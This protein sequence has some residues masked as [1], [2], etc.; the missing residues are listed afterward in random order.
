ML[1]N[2]DIE[3]EK[4]DRQTTTELSLAL[5][6]FFEI[7]VHGLQNFKATHPRQ[8]LETLGLNYNNIQVG[9]ISGQAHHRKPDSFREPLVK[10]GILTP[11][12]A[13]V[14]SPELKAYTSFGNYSITF[15]LKD[16]TGHIVNLYAYRFKI[17][18]PKEEYL[19]EE[20]LYPGFPSE[21]TTR[22][23]V[24]ENVIDAVSLL[25]SGILE[26]RDA[27]ISLFNGKVSSDIRKAIRELVALKEFIVFSQS[28][29]TELIEELNAVSCITPQVGILPEKSLN[30][31]WVKY[32][33]EGLQTFIDEI[34][35]SETPSENQLQEISP[36]EF[37]Y[38]GK[39]LTYHI[40]GILPTNP[41]LLEMQ[42]ELHSVDFSE[43]Y[44]IKINLLNL[45][46]SK[47]WLYEWTEGKAINY[48]IVLSELE[49]IR[50]QLQRIKMARKQEVL[51][52]RGF[53]VAQDKRAKQLLRSPDLMRELDEWIER[54]GVVGEEKTRLLLFIIA[55]SY[56]TMYNLHAVVQAND[57]AVGAELV[58]SIASLITE[59]DRYPLDVTTSRSFRY[60]GNSVINRKLLVIA[61]Y[62][63]II[64]SKAITD[65]K[66]LQA[67]NHFINDAPV[68]NAIGELVTN[69]KTIEGHTSSIGASS[70]ARKVFS[71][72]PKTVVI[73]LDTSTNQM[74]RLMEYDCQRIAGLIDEEQQQRAKEM[75]HYVLK[76]VHPLAVVNPHANSLMIPAHIPNA[77]N[78]TIQL[79]HFTNLITLFHQHQRN[80]DD[81]GRLIVQKEDLQMAMDLFLNTVVLNTD[82]LDAPTLELFAKL[83]QEFSAERLFT[84]LEVQQLGYSKTHT[85]RHLSLLTASEYLKKEG[86]RNTGFVY[87]IVQ[88]AEIQT[89]KKYI[90]DQL[91]N[92]GHSG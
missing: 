89:I 47:G 87:R 91:V 23:F 17:Q 5:K 18:T 4:D 70:H 50:E 49:K 83:K 31:M 60:Y 1:I 27:V 11:S 58:N 85:N 13:A 61:D 90:Q 12:D 78:L 82:E 72:E 21:R 38:T 71:D 81:K 3:M 64:T 30:E 37:I 39:Q 73:D 55:S 54:A 65:L 16:E 19:N 22:L 41:S 26:N 68:K 24:T 14:R 42:F 67:N 20:G 80:K 9:F 8:F 51:P 59:I 43:P 74:K 63:G 56:P 2:K 10:L 44:P 29:Q 46:N 53:S 88:T 33:A 57:M 40:Y 62:S 34:R 35:K 45:T 79:L 6:N 48:T 32:G 69:R 28:E 75:I 92:G 52:A 36:T 76:N 86:H 66:R 77:R 15:P 84:S 7:S 25:Q